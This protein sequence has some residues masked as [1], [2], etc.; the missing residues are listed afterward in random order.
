MSGSNFFLLVFASLIILGFFACSSTTT[1][2]NTDTSTSS[3]TEEY[4][5]LPTGKS[6]V[7]FVGK[8]V[9]LMGKE[10]K[11][12]YQHMMKGSFSPDGEKDPEKHI[13]IDYNE[14]GGQIVGYYK[15]FDIPKDEAMHKFYGKILSMSGA[16]KGGG[17]HTE[18]YIMLDKV[19]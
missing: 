6:V 11:M 18:Y 7:D 15:G 5:E 8:K 16:G 19:E 17:M 9:W 14:N 4:I 2:T 10:S 12:V 3:S 1:A 13:Y